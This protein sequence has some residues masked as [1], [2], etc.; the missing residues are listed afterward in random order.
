MRER[1]LGIIPEHPGDAAR[2]RVDF[3][4]L[5]N[6]MVDH[7]V[8]LARQEQTLKEEGHTLPLRGAAAL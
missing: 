5:V 3:A 8:E 6:M 7:D 2:P 4:G 1:S